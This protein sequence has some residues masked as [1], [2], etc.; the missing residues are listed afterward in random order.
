MADG[1]RRTAQAARGGAPRA[2]GRAGRPVSVASGRA[3]QRRR[4]DRHSDDRGRPGDA[5][6]T[7]AARVGRAAEPSRGPSRRRRDRSSRAPSRRPTRRAD[8]EHR[9]QPDAEPADERARSPAARRSSRSRRRR[10]PTSTCRTTSSRCRRA[11]TRQPAG[12]SPAAPVRPAR[13]GAGTRSSRASAPAATRRRPWM[14]RIV[15]LITLALAAA[16]VWFLIELFQPFGVSPHG[17]VTV[18]DPGETSSSD[19]GGCC[20]RRRDLLALL[21]RAPR[22]ARRQP[23][24]HPCGHLSPAAGHELRG[25]AEQAHRGRRRRRRR[26]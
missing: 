23:P 9:G 8:A 4:R 15:A 2:R 21:L 11:P 1:S 12:Q 13:P 14:G 6:R 7:R 5:S 19:V 18:R 16:I 17:H 26:S 22:D 3:D 20:R 24:R 10:T 25:G